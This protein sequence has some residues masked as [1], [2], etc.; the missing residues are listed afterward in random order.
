MTLKHLMPFGAEYRSERRT[1]FRLW[2]PTAS[3]VALWLPGA[4]RR[5]AMVGNHDGWFELVTEAPPGTHYQY[6]INSQHPVP[7]P[8]SRFQPTAVHGV[9]E[10][11]DPEVFSWRDLDWRGRPWEEAVIYELHV[12]TFS[13]EGT[14]LGA[15]QKLD[16][17]ARLGITAIELMPLASFPGQRNWGYDG[18]LPYAPAACYGRGEDLKEFI[19][20]AHGNNLMVLLDVVYNHFGPEGNYLS[21]YAPQFFTDRHHTP[22]GQAINFDGPGSRPVRDFFIHNALYWLEEYH[23][24]GLRLDAVHAIVDDS[25]THILSEMAGAIRNR[26]AGQRPIHLLLENDHNTAR[27]L[28]SS[29]GPGWYTA[30]W[31]DDLH[32]AAHVMLTG[33]TDGYYCDYAKSPEWHLGRCLTEGYSYQGEPS[34]FRQG[35]PRGEPSADLPPT[36]FVSFLQNH[37]QVG[38]RALGER[39]GQ[40]AEPEALKA[41]LAILLL[42]PSPPLLF[43]G[44]EFASKTPFLYFCDFGPELSAKVRDG[45]RAEFA[46][47]DQFRSPQEQAQIPDPNDPAT[48]QHSKLDWSQLEHTEHAAWLDFYSQLLRLRQ[49]EIVPRIQDLL[50]KQASF[51]VLR[52]LAIHVRWKMRDGKA[53]E[54]WANLGDKPAP[55]EE[56]PKGAMLYSTAENPVLDQLEMPP[57]LAAWFLTA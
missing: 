25:P 56:K 21:L 33:E 9:S 23:L 32:H 48:F 34:V 16:Y 46:R 22:W 53:L 12:G 57:F 28:R 50:P 41:V 29:R 15:L 35:Q 30:Q 38:N 54:L 20:A 51:R 10:V 45:R 26:F 14:F 55:L 36:C 52:P 39:I 18:V 24:D 31:N 2:A 37:D 17:L 47:F 44:E 40:L 27:Y 43:M 42:A 7:D 11:I 8:A 1:R 6:V 49:K 19:Q 13:P 4:S 5:Q 3:S